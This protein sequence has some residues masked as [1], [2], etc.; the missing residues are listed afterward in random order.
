MYMEPYVLPYN[1]H[2][3]PSHPIPPRRS[4]PS[5]PIPSHPIYPSHPIPPHATPLSL[6]MVPVWRYYCYS[7]LTTHY[8]LLTTHYP[9]LTTPILPHPIPSNP[10]QSP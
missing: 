1:A 9:L 3:I 6:M 10:I 5:H 8:P 4:I 2:P 7:L